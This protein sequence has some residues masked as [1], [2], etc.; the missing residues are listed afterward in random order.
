MYD[1]CNTESVYKNDFLQPL[2]KTFIVNALDVLYLVLNI[3]FFFF[4]IH[5]IYYVYIN[6]IHYRLTAQ[7]FN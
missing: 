2:C 4:N 7:M 3:D 1:F 6:A 5:T